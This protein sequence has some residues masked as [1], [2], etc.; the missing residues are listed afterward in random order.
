MRP[1]FSRC[2]DNFFTGF[3]PPRTLAPAAALAPSTTTPSPVAFTT[4]PKPSPIPDV[5]AKKTANGGPPMFTPSK[6][7][8]VGQPQKQDSQA[9]DP[10]DQTSEPGKESHNS[11]QPEKHPKQPGS[12][13]EAINGDSQQEDKSNKVPAEGKKPTAPFIPVP[14]IAAGGARASSDQNTDPASHDISPLVGNADPVDVEPTD[15]NSQVQP[16]D[17]QQISNANET[18][19]NTGGNDPSEVRPLPV[20]IADPE[21]DIPGESSPADETEGQNEGDLRNRN[22][23]K[24]DQSFEAIE[25]PENDDSSSNKIPGKSNSAED[26]MGESM[27]KNPSPN[28]PS[29]KGFQDLGMENMR[30]SDAAHETMEGP[31]K[32]DPSRPQPLDKVLK[33]IGEIDP[34]NPDQTVSGTKYEILGEPN[35]SD[36]GG[37]SKKDFASKLNPSFGA[38]DDVGTDRSS[39]LNSSTVSPGN[40]NLSA[41]DRL[42]GITKDPE[43]AFLDELDPLFETTDE[44]RKDT[45]N[46]Y[47]PSP[48]SPTKESSSELESLFETLGIP[49][50]KD[51]ST[52]TSLDSEANENPAQPN[53]TDESDDLPRQNDQSDKLDPLHVSPNQLHQI[54]AALSLF[55]QEA[56]LPPEPTQNRHGVSNQHS[57][58]DRSSSTLTNHA[59]PIPASDQIHTTPS[60]NATLYT[61][62]ASAN[63]TDRT[64]PSSASGS[65]AK[66]VSNIDSPSAT[67][68][69]SSV[70][71]DRVNTASDVSVMNSYSSA[72]IAVG[73]LMFL[74]L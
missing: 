28:E 56:Q 61:P 35:V 21:N 6:I 34:S 71:T 4:A 51:P 66:A 53:D 2:V 24:I 37:D 29:I 32:E 10:K 70:S 52:E 12:K 27:N 63:T 60:S 48:E 36:I 14:P 73:L 67:R 22:R 65:D 30:G 46:N 3:D 69:D 47:P 33:G 62:S 58:L 40:E 41:L 31:G 8:P 54:N 19:E 25:S 16:G 13:S 57:S 17:P 49:S 44:S 55:A 18:V 42:F 15:S 9:P 26:M 5:G 59:T 45:S 1:Y 39:D 23:N 43:K 7:L 38:M 68:T 20:I 50:P 64:A 72:W 11:Q 74:G